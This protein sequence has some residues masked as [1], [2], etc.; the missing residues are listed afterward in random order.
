MIAVMLR[1]QQPSPVGRGAQKAVVFSVQSTEWRAER[2]TEATETVMIAG[3]LP[4]GGAVQYWC[5]PD[6]RGI[7]V[8]V[9]LARSFPEEVR[10]ATRRL[11]VH[12]PRI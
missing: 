4:P 12:C 6:S 7:G 3:P 10:H 8:I 11:L 1:E 2:L 9:P 5:C